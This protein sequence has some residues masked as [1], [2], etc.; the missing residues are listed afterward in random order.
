M[1]KTSEEVMKTSKVNALV[2]RAGKDFI[3]KT[4]YSNLFRYLTNV[5]PSTDDALY[6]DSAI[7]SHS[8]RAGSRTSIADD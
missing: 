4:D 2:L 5:L 7:A 3:P 6:S 1:T 8:N